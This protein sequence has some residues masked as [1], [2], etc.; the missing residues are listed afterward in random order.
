MLHFWWDIQLK[1]ISK[2]K[3]EFEKVQQIKGLHRW[4]WW[5]RIHLPVQAMQET[6]RLRFD[7]GWGG[8]REE[9]MAAHSSVL[10]WRITW[11]AEPGGPQSWGHR[12]LDETKHKYFKVRTSIFSVPPPS[13]WCVLNIESLSNF[14]LLSM[15]VYFSTRRNEVWTT[16]NIHW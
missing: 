9:E 3:L 6:K 8:S 4:R 15:A 1:G 13:V 12:E 7:P 11:T 14:G 2:Q 5:Q 10:S 16:D